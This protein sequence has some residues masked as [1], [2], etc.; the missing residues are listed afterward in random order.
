M[1]PSFSLLY[2]GLCHSMADKWC[3]STPGIWTSEPRLLKLSVPNLTT[4]PRGQPHKVN[5]VWK[6]FEEFVLLKTE[7]PTGTA[8]RAFFLCLRWWY[9]LL[10][11]SGPWHSWWYFPN[12][13]SWAISLA[14]CSE[15][16]ERHGQ[17]SGLPILCLLW[18]VHTACQLIKSSEKSWSE[19]MLRE[20]VFFGMKFWSFKQAPCSGTWA[21]PELSPEANYGPDAAGAA[22]CGD[23]VTLYP[24]EDYRRCFNSVSEC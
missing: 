21:N 2:V 13:V 4:M 10:K 6:I 11:Y 16:W 8:L 17:I 7:H 1:C 3:R 5:F 14:R 15:K 18:E 22:L 24:D 20:T 9:L 12:Y 23:E 19:E